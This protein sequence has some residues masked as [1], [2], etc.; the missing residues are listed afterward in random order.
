MP[1]AVKINAAG[2]L[3]AVHNATL[4]NDNYMMDCP[5]CD[6]EKQHL[7]VSI[8]KQVVH[9]FRCSHS[10]SIL[11]FIQ[12]VENCSVAEVFE[13]VGRYGQVRHHNTVFSNGK[14]VPRDFK[15]EGYISIPKALKTSS[16]AAQLA[17]RYLQHRPPHLDMHDITFWKLGISTASDYAGRIIIPAFECNK[18]VYFGARKFIGGG[19]KYKFPPRDAFDIGKS[20]IVYNIDNARKH[21]DIVICEGY[22]DVMAAGRNA[23]AV[24]GKEISDMQVTK[25][26]ETGCRTVTILLDAGT[27]DESCVMAKKFLGNVDDV[28]IATLR[29]GDPADAGSTVWEK[30]TKRSFK[31]S[32]LL[33]RTMS[34]RRKHKRS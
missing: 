34:G 12:D 24:M 10:T 22:F 6:D 31:L 29:N 21:K 7:G 27:E 1:N 32:T 17:L 26:I 13:I 2:Y 20:K 11:R 23:V 19:P 18:L 28:I 4:R 9:C 25:I 30:A 5:Y 15:I 8:I 14:R 16:R 33:E 3:I